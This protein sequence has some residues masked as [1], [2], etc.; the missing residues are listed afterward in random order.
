MSGSPLRFAVL[1]CGNVAQRHAQCLADLEGTRLVAVADPIAERAEA[2]ASRHGV[3]AEA[4]V[5]ALAHSVD[6]DAVLVSTP[7]TLHAALGTRLVEQGKH[8]LLEKPID[9]DPEAARALVRLSAERDVRLS[10]VSQHRFRDDIGWLRT[11]AVEQPLGRPIHVYAS[12]LWSRDQK[13]YESAP[14]RGHTDRADGGVLLNQ[15][16]HTVDLLL[17][18]FGRAREVSAQLATLTHQI[19]VEDSAVVNATLASGVLVTLVASTSVY[20]QRS[21][22]F[23]VR[24][25]HGTVVL[26]GGQIRRIETR[27]DGPELTPPGAESPPSDALEGFRRQYRDF[28]RAARGGSEPCV[29][30]V[31]SCAVLDFIHAAYRSAATGRS[32]TLPDPA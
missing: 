13:Y 26:D 5:D 1:G 15:A 4:G 16:V 12:S 17:W 20:P 3:R 21:E 8:V 29:T 7:P 14:G 18:M 6:V 30:G 24:F 25:E 2:L 22:S 28:V 32:V 10:V 23:E 19:A 27:P 9:L 11:L 31:E